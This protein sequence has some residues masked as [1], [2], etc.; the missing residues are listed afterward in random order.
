MVLLACLASF[1]FTTAHWWKTE[2]EK[3]KKLKTLPVLLLQLYPQYKAIRII[4]LWLK[5]DFSWS[6]EKLKLERELGNIG[7]NEIFQGY[8]K[9]FLEG[10]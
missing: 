5:D 4:Y 9:F 3:E 7:K 6:E 2:K 8:Q 10:K 1:L